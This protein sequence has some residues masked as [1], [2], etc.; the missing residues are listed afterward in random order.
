MR[1]FDI[2]GSVDAA[3][4]V[5]L[6]AY[7]LHGVWDANNPIGSHVLA[8]TNLTEIDRALDLLWRNDIDAGKVN[9]GIGF[10][11][12]SFQLAN[13]A[14]YKP[15]CLF[16]GGASPGPCTD[17]SGTLSYQEIMDVIDKYD[18]TPY[19]DKKAAVK[20]V[21]WGG[22]Q[23]V[24]LDDFDTFRQ[25]IEFANSLGL[26]VLMVWAVDLDTVQ[27]DALSALIYPESL[28]KKGAAASSAN[29]WEDADQGEC[30]RTEC[31][32]IGCD[33]GYIRIERSACS[34]TNLFGEYMIADICCP[35]ASAPDPD[36]W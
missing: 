16:V 14:C 26:G 24:S 17:N 12:R 1:H 20:W 25:K 4:F 27:L 15:G 19:H 18:L 8:H 35:M 7:D 32:T 29:N 33:T 11:G 10:Y 9:L 21:T 28:G 30:Y 22:D 36:K 5:N 34:A 6:M 2:K 23:W 31:G 13:P 3:N